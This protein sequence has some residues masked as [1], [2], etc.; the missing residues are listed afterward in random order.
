MRIV[1]NYR[2]IFMFDLDEKEASLSKL[3][4]TP[5]KGSIAVALYKRFQWIISKNILTFRNLLLEIG[6]D[7][8]RRGMVI[9]KHPEQ[10]DS[11]I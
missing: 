2:V 11:F 3:E 10:V 8:L 1:K 9:V 7:C 6:I 5:P 4:G